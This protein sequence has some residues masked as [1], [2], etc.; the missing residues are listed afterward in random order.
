MKHM[1]HNKAY[2]KYEVANKTRTNEVTN[3]MHS[4]SEALLCKE[5]IIM[6]QLLLYSFEN[7][8]YDLCRLCIFDNFTLL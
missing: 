4:S 7:K 5:I 2:V 8:H 3:V 1:Q 6:R